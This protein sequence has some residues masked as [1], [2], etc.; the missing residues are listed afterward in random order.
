MKGD[1]SRETFD[2]KKRYNSVRMQ[3]GRVLLDADWNEQTELTRRRIEIEAADLI[4]SSGA[5]MWNDGFRIVAEAAGLSAE[6][7]AR[8]A[9]ASPPAL[10]GGGDFLITGGRIYV[11]GILC[12]NYRIMAFTGQ[13]D[14]PDA[15]PVQDAGLYIA[16]LDVWSRH[17]SALEDGA[18]REVALGGPDTTTRA[19]T[20]RQVKLLRVGDENTV[21]NCAASFPEWAELIAPPDGRLT[22]RAEPDATSK[23]P[24]IVAAGAGYRRLEN[25]LYRVEVHDAGPRGT[26]TFKWSRDN[27]SV[28]ARWESQDVTG[29]YLTLGSDSVGRFSSGDWVELV[30]ETRVLQGV[31]GTLVRLSTAEGRTIRLDLTTV[32]GGGST[33]IADF[34]R[35]PVVRR[36]DNVDSDGVL[37]PTNADWIDLEDGVQVRVAAGEY[38]TGD[39][40]LIPARTVTADVEWPEDS[41]GNPLPQPPRGVEHDYCRLALMRFDG[42]NWTEINDCRKLFPPVTELTSFFYLGGDGQEVMPD[43]TAP[44]AFLPLDAPLRVGVANGE[45]PVQGAR[46]QFTVVQG[47]GQLNGGGAS[48]IVTTNADG[49]ASCSFQ[50]NSAI[51]NPVQIVEA[52]L[53]KSDNTP[54]HLAIRFTATLS[55][56]SRVA[57]V[58]GA[59][60]RLAG[61][62][63]VQEALDV[64]CALNSAGCS[65][66]ISPGE[67]W[68]QML[69]LLINDHERL[70]ICFEP[71]DYRLNEPIRFVGK[72][73]VV[74]HGA[75]NGTRFLGTV[76]ESVF[77]FQCCQSVT[78]H[79]FYAEIDGGN[80]GIEPQGKLNGVVTAI[81]CGQIA[82]ERLTLKSAP[83]TI[84]E[85]TCI[86]VRNGIPD[87]SECSLQSS[88]RIKGCDLLVGHQQTGLLVVNGERIT[89]EDN[90]LQGTG[91][92]SIAGINER[93]R[94]DAKFR[95]VMA[96]R[97]LNVQSV[98]V[99]TPPI[100]GGNL[101]TEGVIR[102]PG[103]TTPGVDDG[104]KIGSN[105]LPGRRLLDRLERSFGQTSTTTI[106]LR[107]RGFE[108]TAETPTP[109]AAMW[110][111]LFDKEMERQ[112]RDSREFRSE[113]DRIVEEMLIGEIEGTL[114]RPYIT[115]LRE[116]NEVLPSVASQGIVV[117]GTTAPEVR[118][119]GNSVE[120]V[121]QGIHIG[122]S[123]R[124][125]PPGDPEA[126]DRAGVIS[127]RDNSVVAFLSSEMRG[128]RHGIFVGN[129]D[130][131]LI[132]GN[133][134]QVL[135]D[136]ASDNLTIEGI[137]VYGYLGLRMIARA[138]HMEGTRIGVRVTPLNTDE[139]RRQWLVADTIAYP[140]VS[141]VA[142]NS[143]QQVN[144]L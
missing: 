139:G 2:P 51:N 50:L 123:H 12:E 92:P 15:E 121:R 130:S 115:W 93:L 61:T 18:I 127:I 42:T 47:G 105:V 65:I 1:L 4:G 117:G 91:R 111:P 36:W 144:N 19:K 135:W 11:D 103:R 102:Q 3:Q 82:L 66:P 118:I 128:E 138:N 87:E 57:Y 81:D 134:V 21:G 90:R 23:D 16:Y 140:G 7:A 20:T 86:T 125:A 56:A 88:T 75:G 58:P 45:H 99:S 74:I 70:T 35:S 133:Y 63:T 83:G 96:E 33:D 5:P 13:D 104:R 126:F 34:P 43:P 78:L 31:P 112:I 49:V 62:K 54:V 14:L 110:G 72:E 60:D 101:P 109:M 67:D 22:A 40:W 107:I 6:E 41:V 131:L 46:V 73:S 69:A 26:A 25:Q 52:R 119:H 64:L 55:L 124:E 116:A 106:T 136:N 143:V 79:D 32:Q 142:P 8:P 98:V 29:E 10:Q 30:D 85:M 44:A 37:Q 9:N 80:N 95:G 39:Y 38:R 17:I 48:V 27:G 100:R 89:I 120:G 129:S 114:V 141:V 28:V 97:V 76:T 71:G 77:V 53:L 137:K 84:R 24:C 59:C 132:E 94:T 122:L 68:Q 113:V 108:M